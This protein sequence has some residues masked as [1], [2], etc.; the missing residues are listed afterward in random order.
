MFVVCRNK[1]D[2]TL[3]ITTRASR[4]SMLS[5]YR[6]FGELPESNVLK[7]F[8]TYNDALKYKQEQERVNKD[9]NNLLKDKQ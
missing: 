2:N 7:Q 5:V 6:S 3:F 4:E 8:K 9:L 1:D